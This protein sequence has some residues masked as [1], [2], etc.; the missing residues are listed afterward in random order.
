MRLFLSYFLLIHS[1]P[2][3]LQ[4]EDIPLL[5]AEFTRNQNAGFESYARKPEDSGTNSFINSSASTAKHDLTQLDTGLDV[6]LQDQTEGLMYSHQ[7]LSVEDGLAARAVLCGL[8]D[9]RGF[10]WLGTR[11]GLNRFDGEKFI[12][13]TRRDGLQRN[14]V[15][16]LVEDK[17]GNIWISYGSR[18]GSNQPDGRTDIYN[19][20]SGEIVP[21]EDKFPDIPFNLQ[22]IQGI[23]SNKEGDIYFLI[24]P[25]M[26][27][28]YAVDKGFTMMTDQMLQY[29]QIMSHW[30][31][32]A[33]A[34]GENIALSYRY[35]FF[36]NRMI[37]NDSPENKLSYFNEDGLLEYVSAD[38]TSKDTRLII[39]RHHPEGGVTTESKVCDSLTYSVLDKLDYFAGRWNERYGP[40]VMFIIDSRLHVFKDYRISVLP[41]GSFSFT[42]FR[43]HLSFFS[44]LQGN[45]WVG[46]P[47]GL[48][49]FTQQTNHFQI[50]FNKEVYN[51]HDIRSNQM[52]GIYAD[53]AGNVWAAG[54]IGMGYYDH[55][56]AKYFN[57]FNGRKV[58]IYCI[59]QQR[60]NI[61]L[62]G[63][64]F[65]SIKLPTDDKKTSRDAPQLPDLIAESTYSEKGS[66]WAVKSL[67]NQRYLIG[68]NLGKLLI[69]NRVDDTFDQVNTCGPQMPF[70]NYIYKII[71]SPTDQ[72]YWAVG[73][74]GCYRIS[75]EYCI[76]DYYGSEAAV[77]EQHRI[78]V[79]NVQDLYEDAKGI[80]WLASNGEG[81]LRWDR[82]IG[83]F[84]SFTVQD[85]LPSN[86]L[87]CILPDDFGNLWIS[88]DNGLVR[89]NTDNH[90][91]NVFSTK[92]GIAHNEFNRISSF[93]AVDGRMYFG[94][95]DGVTTFH[96]RDFETDY[97]ATRIP[98]ALTS[99]HQFLSGKDKLTDLT[100]D[101]LTKQEITLKP[102]DRFFRL[103]F[104]LL[105][106]RFPVNRYKYLIEGLD[107]EWQYIT[108]PLIQISGL[109]YGNYVL[110]IAGQRSSG[111]W[112][113]QELIYPIHVLRPYY[114]TWWAFLVY[115][116]AF[117]SFLFYFRKYQ[118]R[119]AWEKADKIRL[120]EINS[121]KTKLY[122]NIT[123]EFRTPL[124]VI[125]GMADMIEQPLHT[126]EMIQRNSQGLLHLVNQ[127]LD[128]SKLESG[129]LKLDLI[130][131]DVVP[132]IKY[133]LESFQSFASTKGISLVLIKA[134]DSV[135]MD[136]D[137]IKIKSVIS[138]LL[139]NAI[140]FSKENG[141]VAL[142]LL[143]EKGHLEIRVKDNGIGIPPDKLPYIF[144]SFYQVDDSSTR[145]A[146]GTGIGLTLTKE[147]VELM[148]GKI[149]VQSP[150]PDGEGTEFAVSLPLTMGA[151]TG[152]PDTTHFEKETSQIRMMQA[153]A[154][155]TTKSADLPLLLIIE[156]N[157][158]LVTYIQ[159]CLRGRYT[160][161]WAENGAIGIE[162][163]REII[164]DVI[165][166][167]VMMP[168]K[169]GFE[170]CRTLKND[171]L[172]SH[173]PIVLLTARI[174]DE[175]RLEGLGAGADAYLSKPFLKE[176]LFI[177]MEKLLEL[178]RNLKARYAGGSTD[179]VSTNTISDPPTLD[180]LFLQKIRDLVEANL[181]VTSFGNT[182][183][184][185]AML[186]S[187]SQLFRKVKALTGR[188]TA[189]HIRSIRLQKAKE[190]LLDPGLTVSEIAYKTGFSDPSY[191]AR[192]FSKE[193]G[194]TPTEFRK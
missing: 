172:T 13:M 77:D 46:A 72:H 36:G 73:G 68:N 192:T 124:T 160:F 118:I 173:I 108:E 176:E 58:W 27:Y 14:R 165:I 155:S 154:G 157:P 74:S 135:V 18:E 158:D 126:K 62:F 81:L 8:Q 50:L 52:R 141:Q 16:G 59:D 161:A 54:P 183:L 76:T 56:E 6:S 146:E 193:F 96:P 61:H 60:D 84:Q 23:V 122:T 21:I 194:R 119:R 63:T 169:D 49:K 67:P 163:A 40:S 106:Y 83:I 87:Y 152:L 31:F 121:F 51:S 75:K 82:E 66:F 20:I 153:E 120:Q 70:S 130:Q 99:F 171:M 142:R 166:S 132:Y 94:G 100:T 145:Q 190:M 191:F 137:E 33:H 5:A 44:D 131:A 115:G 113:E 34:Q 25:T 2:I 78:P 7:L 86:T 69:W 55:K 185:A 105:D 174:D 3:P 92:D 182:Q 95:I 57:V 43:Y 101:L 24:R 117:L 179:I 167:D 149:S 128:L 41:T 29:D 177:R 162:K 89:F 11:N 79:E 116:L 148:G 71:F 93:K 184:A 156:D 37:R 39:E 53:D 143:E 38:H 144:D 129:S 147:L 164:P 102:G 1:F 80:F 30:D 127:M 10:L 168:E 134:P 189:I 110:R 107:K 17:V 90:V 111:T 97:A 170:V 32:K 140:K 47:S 181:D 35:S 139:F 159:A 48:H 123:H 178:R 103:E 187:E 150:A 112:S 88:T 45:L 98:L 65:Y 138:N 175:S 85:G 186:V 19:P 28:R 12:L 42:D 188:S 133:L 64:G 109:K 136:F 151:L 91:I 22:D 9:Q 114:I 4:G 104:A 15:V 26:L 125:L 180:G